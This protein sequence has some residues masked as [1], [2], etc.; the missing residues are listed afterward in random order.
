MLSFSHGVDFALE[1]AG[2]L[3]T[4]DDLLA[5]IT[6]R[7]VTSWTYKVGAD[8][9]QD[10]AQETW[11]ALR[12]GYSHLED[13]TELIKLAFKISRYISIRARV[14]AGREPALPEEWDPVAIG[15]GADDHVLAVQVR[16]AI[17]E[18]TGRCP[19]LLLLL[20]DGY[21][22]GEIKGKM[23]APKTDTVYVW[24]HRCIKALRKKLGIAAGDDE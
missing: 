15:L 14:R 21:T 19:E 17:R 1:L 5:G 7:L 13:E 11:L 24:I 8:M 22:A 20:L 9:A 6:E 3:M 12:K 4:R 16:E 10:I 2:K 23:G 18:L